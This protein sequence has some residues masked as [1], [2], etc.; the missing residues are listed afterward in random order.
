MI[1]LSILSHS[2]LRPHSQKHLVKTSVQLKR[3]HCISTSWTWSFPSFNDKDLAACIVWEAPYLQ[4]Y[5]NQT[6][7]RGQIQQF[8]VLFFSWDSFFHF[9][10]VIQVF[11]HLKT[12]GNNWRIGIPVIMTIILIFFLLVLPN[13][14]CT[15]QYFGSSMGN[16]GLKIHLMH[17]FLFTS[18]CNTHSSHSPCVLL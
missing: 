15:L 14:W 12:P 7:E 6:I 17:I 4:I 10:P 18:M 5:A 3:R 11:C 9:K 13:S 16:L 1:I 8:R 2:L